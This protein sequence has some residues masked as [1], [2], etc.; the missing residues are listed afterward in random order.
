ML[1]GDRCDTCASMHEWMRQSDHPLTCSR[2][3]PSAALSVLCAARGKYH[4]RF[5]R[6]Q[7]APGVSRKEET[8]LSGTSPMILAQNS[9]PDET[10]KWMAGPSSS[11]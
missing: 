9:P 5:L 10:A 3:R 4:R 11:T 2:T 8:T 6:R 1:A 7:R